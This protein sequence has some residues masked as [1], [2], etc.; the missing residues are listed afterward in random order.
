MLNDFP[1]SF[2]CVW[3]FVHWAVNMQQS[4]NPAMPQMLYCTMSC[5]ILILNADTVFHEIIWWYSGS[6]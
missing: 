2:I 4:D 5:E 6:L 1:A 3:M